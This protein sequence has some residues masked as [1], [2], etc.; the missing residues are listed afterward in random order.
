MV[1]AQNCTCYVVFHRNDHW[2]FSLTIDVSVNEGTSYS[3]KSLFV[4]VGIVGPECGRSS[5]H[6]AMGV[7]GVDIVGL[8]VVDFFP[9]VFSLQ[10]AN[11]HFLCFL[12]AIST[13]VVD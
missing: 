3:Q 11:Y 4:D 1:V 13:T 5:F 12:E 10:L 7:G 2:T 8:Q 6:F 9:K